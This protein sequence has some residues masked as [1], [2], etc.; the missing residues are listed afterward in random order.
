MLPFPFTTQ[1]PFHSSDMFAVSQTSED[2]SYCLVLQHSSCLG[3]DTA[4]FWNAFF[5]LKILLKAC[6]LQ[7]GYNDCLI[8]LLSQN[9]Q[10]LI[11]PKYCRYATHTQIPILKEQA[12][13]TSLLWLHASPIALILISKVF[14]Y[15]ASPLAVTHLLSSTQHSA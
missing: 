11:T 6:L 1:Q 2:H 8:N 13:V 7:D 4:S 3:N 9:V 14:R 15:G 5:S 10:Y 12:E